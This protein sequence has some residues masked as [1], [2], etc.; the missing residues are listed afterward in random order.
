MT[1][2][3][4][5]ERIMKIIW[6]LAIGIRIRKLWVDGSQ[7][8][9]YFF[10]LFQLAHFAY[11]MKHAISTRWLANSNQGCNRFSHNVWSTYGYLVSYQSECV[12]VLIKWS[13]M[14]FFF[15]LWWLLS[16]EWLFM[17]WACSSISFGRL[18]FVVSVLGSAPHHIPL[19]Y[20]CL[21]Q[22][23]IRTRHVYL[24][25]GLGTGFVVSKGQFTRGPKS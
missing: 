23:C 6:A 9:H 17:I 7:K 4:L 1:Y 16:L 12:Y 24:G 21:I 15:Q 25:M 8:T 5:F 22:S 19:K 2:Y 11:D 3:T 13:H 20:R 14:F 18:S 10:F